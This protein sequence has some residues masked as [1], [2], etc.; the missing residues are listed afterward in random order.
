MTE[1]IARGVNGVDLCYETMGDPSGD[2]LLLIMGLG[3]QLHWWDD[4]LCQRFVDRGFHVIRFDNRDCGHST[5]MSGKAGPLSAFVLRRS[6]YTVGDMADDA[7][8]LLGR[9]GV[10]RAH[11]VGSSMGGM[12]AQSLAIRWPGLVASLTSIMSTTGNPLVGLPTVSGALA[13]LAASPLDR[14]AFVEHQ[15]SVFRR[16]AAGPYFDE[17]QIR[18]HAATSFDRGLNPDGSG[19]QLAASLAAADRTNDLRAL[20]LPV[21]VLHGADDRL[22]SVSGGLA[23]ARAIPGAEL[24]VFHGMGHSLPVPLFDRFAEIIAATAA[25][26]EPVTAADQPATAEAPADQDANPIH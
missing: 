17:P 10:R 4:E 3:A 23:T 5:S 13:L 16:I 14:Q 21:A 15:V 2:P 26:A 24:H 19:R 9:L 20:R 18:H 7:A 11:V 22:I 12:I 25:R 1:Q 6:P 8:A